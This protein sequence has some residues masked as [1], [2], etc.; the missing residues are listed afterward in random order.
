MPVLITT[1]PWTPIAEVEWDEDEPET[2]PTS[3]EP[4]PDKLTP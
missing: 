2:Q 1:G 4:E 3:P